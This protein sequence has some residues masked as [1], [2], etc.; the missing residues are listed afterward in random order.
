M[1]EEKYAAKDR[2]AAAGDGE[3][4]RVIRAL[5]YLERRPEVDAERIGVTGR[6]GG[7]AYSWWVAALDDRIRAAVPVAG[8]TTLRNHVVDGCVEL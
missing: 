4:A 2:A 8:I 5:D 6:S 3:F 7:G 1:S